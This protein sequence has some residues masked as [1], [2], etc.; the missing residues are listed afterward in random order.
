M[1]LK[2]ILMGATAAAL[3]ASAA[4]AERGSD[5]QLNIL[6]WQAVSIMTPYLSSGTKD[7]EAASLVLEPLARFN[8][9]GEIVP[10]LVT[11]IPTVENGGVLDQRALVRLKQVESALEQ[12]LDRRRHGVKRVRAALRHVC[13]QLLGEERIA[14]RDRDDALSSVLRQLL[15]AGERGEELDRLVRC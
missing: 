9:Q 3:C 12:R 1:T 6:Y 7:L 10:Y 8:E 14:S 4:H 2:G 11:E 13:E 15:A 5:G